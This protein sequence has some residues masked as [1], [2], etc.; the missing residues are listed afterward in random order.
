MRLVEKR[1]MPDGSK[2]GILYSAHRYIFRTAPHMEVN[3][4]G[5]AEATPSSASVVNDVVQSTRLVSGY[6]PHF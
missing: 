1:N 2:R 5:L 3:T 4:T 6:S